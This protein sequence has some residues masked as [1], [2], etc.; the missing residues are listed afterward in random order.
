VAASFAASQD[1]KVAAV[2]EADMVAAA[3]KVVAV[4]KAAVDMAAVAAIKA[5][6]N[7]S[8]TLDYITNNPAP[9]CGII[10]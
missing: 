10:S 6:R 7:T 4:V 9:L 3:V 1:H 5:K 8:I 2:A